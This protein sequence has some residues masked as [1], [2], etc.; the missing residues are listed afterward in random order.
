MAV[1]KDYA[2]SV[3]LPAYT[4]VWVEAESEE[5]AIRQAKYHVK[6]GDVE[7][8]WEADFNQKDRAMYGIEEE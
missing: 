2:V 4:T 7:R 8:L 1:K 6:V 5:D 3:C